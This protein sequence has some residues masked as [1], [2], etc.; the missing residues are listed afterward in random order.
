MDFYS[1]ANGLIVKVEGPVMWM[2]SD[3]PHLK[4]GG[5]WRSTE[6]SAKAWERA[7]NDPDIRVIVLTGK[8]E[9]FNTGGRVNADDPEERRKYAEAIAKSLEI[10]KKV[11]LPIIAAVNGHCLKGGMGILD[12][13]D[14]AVAVDTAMFGYPEVRMGGVPM[15]VMAQN[16]GL[17]KKLLLQACY[18][19][20]YFDA[21]TALRI[22]L[23]NEVVDKEH[24]EETVN[25]YIHMIIDNPRMLIQ[26][27][28]E[29]YF[30]MAKLATT[31]ERVA[32]AQK[33]LAERV[34]PQ[35]ANE[36]QEYNV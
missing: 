35:M 24:F 33:M 7:A 6:E 8:G 23:V 36:K 18:S 3:R 26:M 30:E 9:Y 28:H 31:E 16:M 14:L 21:Q 1:E 25:K 32:F 4:N 17:P 11:N 19:S 10:K 29:A 15:V 12:E 22:G 27:T 2:I 20:Q 34:L 5:D 13:A